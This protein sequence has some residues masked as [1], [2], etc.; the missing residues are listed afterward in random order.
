MIFFSFYHS[1]FRV[2]VNAFFLSFFSLTHNPIGPRGPPP[3]VPA[4]LQEADLVPLNRVL[5]QQYGQG[6]APAVTAS[7][8]GADQSHSG[9][10]AGRGNSRREERVVVHPGKNRRRPAEDGEMT[11]RWIYE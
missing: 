5:V 7:H 3:P 1:N 4:G 8:V 11:L 9:G 6:V 2:N 10:Q